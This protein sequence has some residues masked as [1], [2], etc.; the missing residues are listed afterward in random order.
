MLPQVEQV[1]QMVVNASR[2][3]ARIRLADQPEALALELAKIEGYE[4]GFQHGCL[5]LERAQAEAAQGWSL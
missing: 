3:D 5:S 1:L 4:Q 2:G